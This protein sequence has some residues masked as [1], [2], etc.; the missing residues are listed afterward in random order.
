M[1]EEQE[2]V[3]GPLLGEQAPNFVL[4]TT[5]ERAALGA[6]L[7]K[8]KVLL[9]FFKDPYSPHCRSLLGLLQDFQR[10]FAAAGVSVIAVSPNNMDEL[11]TLSG[12]LKLDYHLASDP[13]LTLARAYDV[14]HEGDTEPHRSVFVID[15]DGMIVLAIDYYHPANITQLE[16]I[17]LALELVEESPPVLQRDQVMGGSL[18]QRAR[19]LF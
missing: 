19:R 1:N 18:W 8:G 4:D 17:F 6:L 2:Q 14:A 9:A 15:P 13:K 12:E 3:M 7:E 11:R 16:A 5:G 10:Q